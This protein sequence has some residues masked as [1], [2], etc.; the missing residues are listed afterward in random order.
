MSDR[1]I[2]NWTQLLLR[3]KS[4][5]GIKKEAAGVRGR[6]VLKSLRRLRAS[7][8]STESKERRVPFFPSNLAAP[9]STPGCQA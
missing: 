1:K 4:A 8:K 5:A 9:S 3:M 6:G 7:R 2:T